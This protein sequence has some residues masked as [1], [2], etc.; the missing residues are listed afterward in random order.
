[1]F[2]AGKTAAVSGAGPDDKFNYVTM[3]LHGDGTNGAQNNTFLDSSTNNFTITRNGNTTQGSFSPYGDNWSNYFDGSSY[4]S[5]AT[6]TALGTGNV[7]VEFW[8]YP[9]DISATYYALYEGRS[10]AS[11]NTGLGIFQYGQTIEIYGNGLKVSSAASAFT[12]NTWTHFAVVR[13]SGTCQIYINGVASGS[14]ASYSDNFTSTTRRI[15]QN[16]AGL[17]TYTGYISNVREVTSALY[18]G[19]FTPSTTPLTAVS[20]TTLLTCQSN[21]F[22][23]NSTNAYTVTANG[24]PS[25]Q[26]F[27]PFGT[28]T[29]YSTSVIGGSGYFDG[30]GDYLQATAGAVPAIGTSDFIISGWWYLNE[31]KDYQ[32]LFDF[33]NGSNTEAVPYVYM[34]STGT[35]DYYVNGTSHTFS[36]TFK[37]KQWY[38]M[39]IS[40]VSGTTKVF[41]N[42]T[43]AVSYSDSVTYVAGRLTL[44]FNNNGGGTYYYYSGYISDF[45]VV[46][47]SGTTSGTPTTTPATATSGTQALLSMTNGA[48]Y[49]NA[50]MNDLETVGNA[51]ISTSV[52]KFGTGSLAFDGTGDYLV[53]GNPSTRPILDFGAGDFTIEAW[54]YPNG[55]SPY[56][57]IGSLDNSSGVGCWWLVVNGTFGGGGTIQ[58][59][60]NTTAGGSGTNILAGSGALSTS[61]WSHIAVTRSGANIRCFVNGTQVGTTNTGIGT[62]AIYPVNQNILVGETVAGPSYGM[63]GY[64]D[65]LR[66]TKGY[67]RY[68]ANFTSPTTAFS[69]TG[70]I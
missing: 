38:Y 43:Q 65:D 41:V 7:T 27:N 45:K 19:T 3:L 61:T 59:A 13:T 8:F 6:A 11:S 26:R 50:M 1:M 64:I 24:T 56:L 10:A 2:A 63:N 67:A 51:Q 37:A 47:G 39:V 25:V 29:A 4:L 44:G 12:A 68:T 5:L 58:F 48:I 36:V 18:S 28:S 66:I 54:V 70:P 40:R 57:V 34:D 42:G 53:V 20:G 69:N 35:A 21:R 46:I 17:N 23:D 55:T 32:I 9:T 52:K 30:S 31:L 33:R 22:I 15:G 49:D 62:S 60:Y 16:A 14:S